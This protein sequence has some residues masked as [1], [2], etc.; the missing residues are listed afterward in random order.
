[1]TITAKSWSNYVQRLR[2]LN[3]K[4]ANL[5]QAYID[6]H[7]TEDVA[8][9]IAYANALV[10]KYGEG[11][12]T[13]AAQMY[14]ELAEIQ[15]AQ[16]AAAVPAE[17]PDYGTVAKMVKATITSPSAMIQG[18]SR[19]VKQAGADT[20]L[21]NARRDRAQFA[22]IPHG[23]TCAFCLMLAS[24]G[25]RNQSQNAM[26]NGH[27]SHIHSNCDCTYAVRFDSRTT[28][29]GY[30]PDR[31]L[32]QYRAA[33]GDLNAMRRENYAEHKDIINAQKR[34][35]YATRKADYM[36][37]PKSFG[38]RSGGVA[39]KAYQVKGHDTLFTQTY[40]ADA[41][42]TI[43]LILDQMEQMP[44][45]QSVP[46]IVVAKDIPG[47][48][49]YDHVDNRLYLN[50]R[51]SSAAY[52]K[53]QLTGDYFVAENAVD[54]LQHEMHH[55]EHWDYIRT[56]ALTSGESSD[57]VKQKVEAE[58]RQ[59]VQNQLASDLAYIRKTVSRNAANGF[60]WYA[61][62][63]ELIA[64]ALLQKDKGIEKDSVLLK[65]VG[66]VFHDDSDVR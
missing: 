12:A 46:E 8:S 35:A 50:E 61:S 9:L 16:V 13:L 3:E 21:Q 56:K 28:V 11:S 26:K 33:N 57:I 59:Y 44:Q 5:M 60:Q 24:N 6:R 31:Y 30:D 32:E 15:N 66:G 34:A 10:T 41:Q 64:D 18:V 63:N 38:D 4:A 54:I 27:A 17:T 52:I 20:T 48:A 19:L 7:G 23:D 37:A 2:R 36:G 65:L 29:A 39:V 47:I 1:M 40:S 25:W 45:L 49:A 55:K 62:L 53:E 51:I 42:G 22:W 43:S 58:L 14:D